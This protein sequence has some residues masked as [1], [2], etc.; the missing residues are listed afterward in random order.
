M[1]PLVRDV[2][3]RRTHPPDILRSH[4]PGFVEYK[5]KIHFLL[6]NPQELFFS[7]ASLPDFSVAEVKHILALTPAID[8]LF[9]LS[10]DGAAFVT[11][12]PSGVR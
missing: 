3:E 9:I 2:F 8:C 4:K 10:I 7:G 5:H 12:Y 11:R 6:R 1:P